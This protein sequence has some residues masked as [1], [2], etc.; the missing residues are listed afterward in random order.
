MQD[1]CKDCIKE[2]YT[3]YSSDQQNNKIQ[4]AWMGQKQPPRRALSLPGSCVQAL[5]LEGGTTVQGMVPLYK[6]RKLELRELVREATVLRHYKGVPDEEGK[7]FLIV[8]RRRI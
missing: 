6:A 3:E 1:K 8:L 5:W 2:V 7:V 4:S